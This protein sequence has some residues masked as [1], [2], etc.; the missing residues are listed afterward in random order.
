MQEICGAQGAVR[1]E[2]RDSCGGED[3]NYQQQEDCAQRVSD[4]LFV[5]K[6]AAGGVAAS[7]CVR[8][9]RGSWRASVCVAHSAAALPRIAAIVA[10][11]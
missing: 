6:G 9:C 8:G 3:N 11:Q 7:A 2:E 10:A 5:W 4:C 1:Q